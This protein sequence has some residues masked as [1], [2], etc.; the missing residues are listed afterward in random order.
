MTLSADSTHSLSSSE[1]ASM[2]ARSFFF[3]FSY[4]HEFILSHSFYSITHYLASVHIKVL[5]WLIW[6]LRYLLRDSIVLYRNWKPPKFLIRRWL[7][8]AATPC[9]ATPF[10]NTPRQATLRHA[11][12]ALRRSNRDRGFGFLYTFLFS[13]GKAQFRSGSQS[14]AKFPNV[15]CPV[16]LGLRLFPSPFGFA[17]GFAFA[18]LFSSRGNSIRFDCSRWPLKTRLPR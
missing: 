14:E 7:S 18:F 10:H 5:F 15:N 16:N 6:M 3:Q 12:S 1:D 4:I 2:A 9:H 11:L 13:S 8:T 17:L